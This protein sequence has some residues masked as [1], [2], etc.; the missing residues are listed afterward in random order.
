[1]SSIRVGDGYVA[2]DMTPPLWSVI[3][4]RVCRRRP[5]KQRQTEQKHPHRATQQLH[6]FS[7]TNTQDLLLVERK[8]FISRPPVQKE[9]V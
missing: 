6:G 1:M 4:P 2:P 9:L 5:V 7:E 3:V 8:E